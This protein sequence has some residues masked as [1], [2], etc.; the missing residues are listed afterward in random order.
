MNLKTELTS[1]KRHCYFF[2][3]QFSNDIL[4]THA[5]KCQCSTY[6]RPGRGFVLHFHICSARNA[7]LAFRIELYYWM[8]VYLSK[9]DGTN[10]KMKPGS[11]NKDDVGKPLRIRIKRGKHLTLKTLEVK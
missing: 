2:S 1:Q 7:V 3:L 8:F 4:F 9:R 11:Q 6:L 5:Y 10:C